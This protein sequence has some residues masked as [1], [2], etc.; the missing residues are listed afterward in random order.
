MMNESTG[1]WEKGKELWREGLLLWQLR[2]EDFEGVRVVCTTL[3]KKGLSRVCLYKTMGKVMVVS[4]GL[5]EEEWADGS[6]DCIWGWGLPS[7]QCLPSLFSSRKLSG[8][9]EIFLSRSLWPLVLLAFPP[10]WPLWAT[11]PSV[12]KDNSSVFWCGKR[13]TGEKPWILLFVVL[14]RQ[15]IF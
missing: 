6:D 11:A 5:E 13:R 8:N 9:E 10:L 14:P 15:V 12:G 3:V 2:K 1:I 7:P 4:R